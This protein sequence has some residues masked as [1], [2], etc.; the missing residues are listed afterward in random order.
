MPCHPWVTATA[1]PQQ[2]GMAP[3]IKGA[4]S[5][6]GEKARHI[7]NPSGRKKEQSACSEMALLQKAS[8]LQTRKALKRFNYSTYGNPRIIFEFFFK[9]YVSLKG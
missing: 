4:A 6:Q 2:L 1:A 7:S 3:R 5:R 8:R 9:K